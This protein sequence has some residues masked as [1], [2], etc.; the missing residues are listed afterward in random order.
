MG[1]AGKAEIAVVHLWFRLYACMMK[2]YT[3]IAAGFGLP[4]V[5]AT[6]FMNF[7]FA[8]GGG[9]GGGGYIP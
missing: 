1:W 5:L 9:G 8:F 2:T 3:L 7:L 4:T 6:G